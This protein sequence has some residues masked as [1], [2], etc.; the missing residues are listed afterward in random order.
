MNARPARRTSPP[1]VASAAALAAGC[2]VAS[3]AA[4]QLIRPA[5]PEPSATTVA[6][7]DARPAMRNP[8]GSAAIRR[9]ANDSSSAAAPSGATAPSGGGAPSGRFESEAVGIGFDV[10]AGLEEVERSP[11][12]D[13]FARYVTP[14]PTGGG[15]S[16]D[17]GTD[18]TADAD[19]RAFTGRRLV[20]DRPTPL[21][22]DKVN[23]VT[24]VGLLETLAAEVAGDSP[25]R[26]V[27]QERANLDGADAGLIAVLHRTPVGAALT[28]I[29]VVRASDQLYHVLTYT[30]PAPA[31][32]GPDGLPDDAA[33]QA[34]PAVRRDVAAFE[35]SANSVAVRD[36]SG[37]RR[38]QD[39][40]L[41]RTRALYANLTPDRLRAVLVPERWLRIVRGGRDVG[42]SYVVEEVAYGLPRPGGRGDD[43]EGDP[44]DEGV[45]VGVRTRT[46][47][48]AG[49]RVDTEGWS[50]SAYDRRRAMWSGVA[51]VTD[52]RP[53]KDADG[54]PLPQEPE[55]G[56]AAAGEGTKPRVDYSTEIGTVT[57]RDK[58]VAV[59]LLDGGGGGRMRMADEH[60]LTVRR[61]GRSTTMPTV[62]RDLPPFYLP[63]AIGQ[64]LPRL[65]AD[66]DISGTGGSTYL[67]ATYAN[68]AG[69]V[70]SRYVDVLPERDVDLGGRTVRA[71]PVEDKLGLEGAVTTHYVSPVDYRYL[72][73][74]NG[75]GV[76]VIPTDRATLENLWAGADLS[77][78]KAVDDDAPGGG[79]AT[80]GTNDPPV[81]RRRPAGR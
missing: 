41:F 15:R 35:A 37:L 22:T 76:T 53:P 19:L 25:R 56:D 16:G 10:P 47:P 12:A 5:P 28:Q 40:R 21:T 49:L 11:A 70:M 63:D 80:G 62:R 75:D 73:S 71:V 60:V 67:F 31:G 68:E 4:G 36:R 2:V 65:V 8:D 46:V 64:V 66:R 58:P 14:Q 32:T 6:P 44:R 48:D 3:G 55:P 39:D 30:T 33:L 50:W 43:L 29:A 27:R 78:P 72:G 38:D 1:L 54:N 74:T 42:Y 79:G 13:E 23:G 81:Q 45:R 57:W 17:G 77:R 59:P 52:G 9:P 61:F 26:T 69:E 51:V 7:V 20:F 34:D 24:R 18:R